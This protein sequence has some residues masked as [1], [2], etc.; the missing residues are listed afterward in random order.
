M[1]QLTVDQIK[2]LKGKYKVLLHEVKLDKK[3]LEKH[4]DYIVCDQMYRV[5]IGK[6]IGFIE[7]MD[8]LGIDKSIYKEGEE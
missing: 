8:I 4:H 3:Q 1:E 7:A 2:L 6:I 5:D